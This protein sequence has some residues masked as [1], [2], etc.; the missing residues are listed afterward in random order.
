VYRVNPA[1][2]AVTRLAT[3]FSGAVNVAVTTTGNVY[4]AELLTGAVSVL[5]SGGTHSTLVRLP[6]ITGLDA[7]GSY[8]YAT[9][10]APVVNGIRTGP[11]RVVRIG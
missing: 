1:T 7:Y 2:G 10:S 11:G 9:Q 5:R 4:V 6:D 3:G 8:L